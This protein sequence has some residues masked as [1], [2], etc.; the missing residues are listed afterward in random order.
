MSTRSHTLS[1]TTL[2]LVLFLGVCLLV[3]Y[4]GSL[5]TLDSVQTWYPL[6]N[7]PAWNPPAWVFGPVWTALY[8]MMGTAAWMVWKETGLF[9]R[10]LGLFFVQLGLNLAWSW[11]FFGLQQPGFAFA[12]IV[13]L[14]VAIV[15]TTR[16]F[17]A[18]SR[19]AGTL[20]VPYVLWTTFAM[21]LN[22]M[23]YQLNL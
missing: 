10:A 8:L 1:N 16:L 13:L 22:W 9:S 19:P 20:L 21:G 4:L 3:G 2:P 6:L 11:I 15:F 12:E 18:V 17:F 23:I 7:K 5:W 14:W